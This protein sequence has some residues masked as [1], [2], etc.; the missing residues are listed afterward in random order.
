MVD[1]M[2]GKC[3]CCG[4]DKCLDALAFHHI[5]P[6]AKDL[7]FGGIRANP[8]NWSNVVAEL[9]KSVLVC[10]NCHSEIHAGVREIPENRTLFNETYAD[11][12][13]IG[14][15][16]S[17]SQCGKQKPVQN[18]YC[19]LSCAGKANYKVDWDNIDLLELMKHHTISELEKMLKVSDNAIYKRKRKILNQKSSSI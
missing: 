16:D 3:Q 14:K 18:K 13:K 19:S 6:K 12:R 15:F 2:G 5:D 1:A 8:T 7:S 9:K 10:H 11:Y 4:Y 17:C